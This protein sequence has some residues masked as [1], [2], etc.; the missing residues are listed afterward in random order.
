[1]NEIN[2]SELFDCVMN[3]FSNFLDDFLMFC[4]DEED[5]QGLKEKVDICKVLISLYL[6]YV[7]KTYN[8]VR[9]V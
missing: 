2:M 3:D 7:N 9:I 5:A 1:M 8:N 4:E 6:K